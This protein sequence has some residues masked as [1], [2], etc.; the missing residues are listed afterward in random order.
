M[1]GLEEASQ[2]QEPIDPLTLLFL[3]RAWPA[4]AVGMNPARLEDTATSYSLYI[5]HALTFIP[6][7]LSC[8][9]VH[10][11]SLCN[12]W[13]YGYEDNHLSLA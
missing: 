13:A 11:Q 6:T 12:P 8:L 10:D 4:Y 9:R 1:L 7:H 5:L 2:P 3:P